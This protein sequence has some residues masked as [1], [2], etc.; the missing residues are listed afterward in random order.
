MLSILGQSF[1]Q[2]IATTVLVSY[3]EPLTKMGNGQA[4]VIGSIASPMA[5]NLIFAVAILFT[6]T[7]IFAALLAK[8][9]KFTKP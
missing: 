9:Y 6:W 5:F 2:I 8:N 7:I 3:T 4:S 1:G